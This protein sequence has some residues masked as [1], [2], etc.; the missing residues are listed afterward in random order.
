MEDLVN[1]TNMIDK[2]RTETCCVIGNYYSLRFEQM[3]TSSV[4]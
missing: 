1:R 4:L 2:Y 3:F